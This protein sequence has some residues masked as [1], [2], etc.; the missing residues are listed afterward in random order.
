MIR[1]LTPQDHDP[2][3]SYLEEDPFHNI[4]LIHGLQTHGLESKHVTFW[5]AFNA[6]Q[7]EGVL[8]ADSDYEPRFGSLTGDDP[9]VLARLGKPA[10]K[11]GV[12]T[13]A[14]KST[15]IRPVT[16]NLP[17]EFQLTYVERLDFYSVGPGKL[18]GRYDYPV[19]V[20]TKDDIP[21][22]VELYKNFELGGKRT[23]EEIEH[24]IRRA[25]DKGGTYFFLEL[26]G[27]AVSGARVF[28]QTDRAGMIDGATTLPEFRRRGMYSCVRTACLEYLFKSGKTGLGVVNEADTTVHKIVRKYGGSFTD[29]WLIVMFRKKP[30][31]RRRVLPSRLRCWASRVKESVSRG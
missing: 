19:R 15:Y 9:R 3:Q 25:M 1:L 8:F 2:V 23:A 21:L 18:L 13:L 6:D 30:P 28:P 17:Y 27:R 22:L 20:A 31:L 4:Y 5:G 10:L 14:G 26:E 24:E 29:Q 16:E 11:S 7:L 12:R